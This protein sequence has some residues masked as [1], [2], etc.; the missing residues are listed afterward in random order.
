MFAANRFS[1]LDWGATPCFFDQEDR[2]SQEGT[3]PRLPVSQLMLEPYAEREAQHDDVAQTPPPKKRSR[4]WF[5]QSPPADDMESRTP[6]DAVAPFVDVPDI[7]VDL[8]DKAAYLRFYNAFRW[9]YGKAQKKQGSAVL[10]V[11]GSKPVHKFARLRGDDKKALVQ[12]FLEESPSLAC[13]V[14]AFATSYMG[15]HREDTSEKPRDANDGS[16]VWL[17]RH[18]CLLTWNGDWGLVPLSDISRITLTVDEACAVLRS[19]AK[20][21]ALRQEV[22]EALEAWDETHR[23]TATAWSLEISPQTYE[24][25]C[26]AAVSRT[27]QCTA[28]LPETSRTPD[29]RDPS[30][31]ADEPRLRLHLHMYFRWGKKTHIRSANI[32]AF[33]GTV[34]V[35]SSIASP[36]GGRRSN[37]GNAGLYYVQAPKVGMIEWGGSVE[38][39]ADYLVNSDWIFNLV[40]QR[41]MAFSDARRELVKSAK[42]LPTKLSALEVWNKETAAESL[43]NHIKGV[44]SVCKA[45]TQPF[46]VVDIVEDWKLQFATIRHRYK[47]LVLEGKSRTGKTQ[48]A[49]ELMDDE[50][51]DYLEI[52]CSGATEPDARDF[53]ALKH[54]LIIFDEGSPSM[55]VRCK[56]LFQAGNC[57][58]RLG[59]SAT[60]CFAYKVW[61]H[62]VRMVICTNRWESCVSDMNEEDQEWLQSN[63]FYYKVED[64]LWIDM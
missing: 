9:W 30:V 6:P 32:F 3:P 25:A 48:F 1:Q 23:F 46:R 64:K 41:K 12:L 53:V 50:E 19:S 39:Y 34:P 59:Q 56:K 55:V 44:T 11:L 28:L 24:Q 22:Q 58:V 16:D 10:Q 17:R 35:K 31:G 52:D 38:P 62:R 63:S 40:Q 13:E 60:N 14:R 36:S 47:F 2:A 61:P 29:P 37:P 27:P 7:P 26:A 43:E 8:K 33:K 42:C 15:F 20:L 45:L 54:K 57:W 5:K 4:L 51:G 18:D 21:A 49:R